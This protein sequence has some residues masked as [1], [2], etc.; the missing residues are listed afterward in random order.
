VTVT[1][2]GLAEGGVAIGYWTFFREPL[3]AQ[4]AS[5]SGY[6]FVCIDHQH[7]A[8]DFAAVTRMIDAVIAGGAT[9]IARTPSADPAPIGALLDA[10]ALGV[11]IP[12]VN[13]AEE[14]ASAVRACRYPPAGE[15][16]MGAIAATV[17]HGDD[18][19]NEANDTIL[20][21]P[22]IETAAAVDQVFAIARTEGID[23]LFVGPSD[24]GASLGRAPALDDPA[25]EFQSAL[26]RVVDAC[27][28]AGIAAGIY[29]S[30]GLMK[31]RLDQGFRMISVSTDWDHII[32]GIDGD[33]RVARSALMHRGPQ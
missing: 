5:Q 2:A 16:S 22:M 30:A 29:G 28:G 23:G 11:I 4:L 27:R 18:Y 9:P 7:G 20:V 24:L 13:T 15:R 14:A 31:R 26:S 25:P 10:G 8:G 3:A 1:R 17:H 19:F 12:M 21:I 32:D 33:L 6:D